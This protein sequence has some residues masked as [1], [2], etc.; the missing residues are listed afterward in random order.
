MKGDLVKNIDKIDE[1]I[2]KI[3]RLR[4]K[5][6]DAREG[7]HAI[8]AGKT[9]YLPRPSGYSDQAYQALIDRTPFYGAYSRTID[10]FIGMVMRINPTID[11]AND[12][13]KNIDNEG[14]DLIDL[15][16]DILEDRLVNGAGGLLVEYS[17][18]SELP[19]TK[20]QAEI[21]GLRPY[22]TE[23][24]WCSIIKTKKHK[25][26][27]TQVILKEDREVF[28]SEFES[29]CI[30]VYKVL[31]LDEQGYY[32]QRTFKKDDKKKDTFIQ[33]DDDFYPLMN[34]G[35]IKEIPFFM[36]GCMDET[37]ELIDLVYLNISHYQNTADVENGCHFTGSPKAWIAGHQLAP[38]EVLDMNS[39]SAWIFADPSA[40]AQYM[41][42][43]GQGLGALEKRIEMKERQMAAIGTKALSDT[44][45]AETAT[46]ASL[47]SAGEFSI[48]AKV[49]NEISKVMSQA[50]SFMYKWAGNTDVS[51]QLNTDFFPNTADPQTLLAW[52]Q[53]Y[54]SG[55]ISFQSL[56]SNLKA[57]EVILSSE[58]AEEE[59]AAISES[60][61][62][63]IMPVTNAN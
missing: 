58:T 42:F 61:P 44:V 8:H 12:L 52:L 39:D 62:A 9:A 43:S 17:S 11:N 27:F 55:S 50:A 31:D 29:E 21:M 15:L 14:N 54:Q 2:E 41:E 49:A 48:L 51:I 33:I 4:K 6:H 22:I 34:G 24:D 38:G 57:G 3:N 7:Q 32:R 23:Y 56:Y 37:P 10:A 26:N 47:R 60:M 28:I 20:L 35:K 5:C 36:F 19:S 25:K 16:D 53:L 18:V 45:V 59:Q 13:L 40:K 46:G 1:E 63:P 30:D